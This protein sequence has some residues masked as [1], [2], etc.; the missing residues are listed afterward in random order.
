VS[1]G[2]GNRSASRPTGAA[3]RTR[4]AIDSGRTADK[5]PGLDPAAA[6]LGTD[7]ESAGAPAA[8]EPASRLRRH[9]EIPPGQVADPSG[10]E[11]GGYLLQDRLAWLAILAA[12][13][14]AAGAAIAAGFLM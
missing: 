1:Q 2:A 5:V 4:N 12:I 3:A 6:P 13:L 10:L 11:R 9:A 14:V 8:A 7:A